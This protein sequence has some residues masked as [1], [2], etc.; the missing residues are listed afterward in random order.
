M[1]FSLMPHV[2]RISGPLHR[3]SLCDPRWRGCLP[4][5]EQRRGFANDGARLPI[6]PPLFPKVGCSTRGRNLQDLISSGC[7]RSWLRHES[8]LSATLPSSMR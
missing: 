6:I 5:H 7:C 2:I 8:R 4:Y 1:Q 3:S